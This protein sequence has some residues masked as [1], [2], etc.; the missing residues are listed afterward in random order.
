MSF[1]SIE[2]AIKAIANGEMVIVVDDENRENEGDIVIAGDAVTAQSV[3]FMMKYARGLICVSLQGERLDELA[4]PLM[5]SRNSESMQT[6][7]TVSVD[8]M[9]GISTGISA[10]DRAKT[11]RALVDPLSKPSDFARPGHIFPLRANPLGV[12][13]RPGHTEAAVD[14]ARLAGHSACGVICEIANDD[15]TMSRLPQ[16]IEFASHHKLHLITIEAL[17]EYRLRLD[18]RDKIS[19]Q[20]VKCAERI[21]ETQ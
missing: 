21:F 8:L 15:G 4:I 19:A 18:L 17:I 12:L 14:L 3:A 2:V 5:V 9:K 11:I 1:S 13:G 10:S 7:F 16:L 6:A 20:N